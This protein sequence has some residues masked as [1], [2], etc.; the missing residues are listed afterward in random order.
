MPEA[1]LPTTLV[2][3]DVDYMVIGNVSI[4]S[5]MAGNSCCGYVPAMCEIMLDALRYKHDRLNFH[6]LRQAS[7]SDESYSQVEFR[8]PSWINHLLQEAES[9]PNPDHVKTLQYICT[10]VGNSLVSP[11]A[12]IVS[13]IRVPGEAPTFTITALRNGHAYVVRGF[14]LST[15]PQPA[16][17]MLMT[18]FGSNC[19]REYMLDLMTAGGQ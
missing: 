13:R 3:L 10:S 17:H 11:C 18:S 15:T 2:M 19:G 6:R 1:P 14:Q 12:C 5:P 7:L 4:Q 16:W 9:T 8:T